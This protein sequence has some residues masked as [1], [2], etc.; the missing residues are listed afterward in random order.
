MPERCCGQSLGKSEHWGECNNVGVFDGGGMGLLAVGCGRIL[1]QW[2]NP[3]QCGGGDSELVL[4]A[5][6]I[7][8]T[9]AGRPGHSRAV[10]HARSQCNTESCRE[11]GNKTEM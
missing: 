11:W 6:W 7:L 2:Q 3:R 4:W 10:G 8:E 1:V 5:G 9:G